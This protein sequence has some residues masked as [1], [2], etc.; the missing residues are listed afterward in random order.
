M[1][2]DSLNLFDDLLLKNHLGYYMVPPLIPKLIMGWTPSLIFGE[3][4]P[5][6]LG[7]KN[8]YKSAKY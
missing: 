6:L 3:S 8:P 1:E 4:I 7:Y 2:I 5:A